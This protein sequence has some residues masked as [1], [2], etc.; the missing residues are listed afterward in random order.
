MEK[1]QSVL[2]VS[3][4]VIVGF[5]TGGCATVTN[6][7]TYRAPY[8]PVKLTVKENAEGIRWGELE[9]DLLPSATVIGDIKE[10]EE[11]LL[12]YITRVRFFTNWP[13]GW[14]E[15]LYEAS[16][17]Y[18]FT[19]PTGSEKIIVKDEFS[20]WDILEG[21]IRY[22]DTYHRR[23]AGRRKVKNRIDRMAEISRY[24]QEEKDFPPFFL[25]YE[26]AARRIEGPAQSFQGA[27]FPYLF[28]E[29]KGSLS[30]KERKRYFR[31]KNEA[32]SS[33]NDGE[34]VLGAG[35][36]WNSC[37]SEKILPE[38]Y[39]ALRDSGTLWRDYEE[40]SHLFYTLYN[41][42]YVMNEYMR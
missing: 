9:T 39:V 24:M 1:K 22:F 10:S 30:G 31:E 26:G 29:A 40:A 19:G 35:I 27:L 2:I 37:Y 12:F 4:I 21:E 7:I 17:T 42:N 34:K 28:P 41:I 11:G 8:G 33:C 6:R 13:N 32:Y 15:G 23:D 36:V 16:G 38:Q 20:L 14:T 5:L 18:L 3:A 25:R